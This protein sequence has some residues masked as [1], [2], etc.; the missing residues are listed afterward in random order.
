MLTAS[1][2]LAVLSL[3]FFVY[4]LW[5]LCL[6]MGAPNELAALVA[7]VGFSS[8]F[9]ARLALRGNR[10]A[11]AKLLRQG[12][13]TLLGISPVLLAVVL[14]GELILL[15]V[16]GGS[17]WVALAGLAVTGLA[18]VW[19][20]LNARTPRVVKVQLP[21]Q[22]LSQPVRFAQIS[23][24]HIGSRSSAFLGRVMEQINATAPDF[25]CITGDF[26]DQPG[27]S[28]AQLSALQSFAGPIFF[29]TGNHEYYE[30][31]DAILERLRNLGVN[32]LRQAG[33]QFGPV[34]IIGVDDHENPDRLAE[35]L[36]PLLPPRG[37]VNEP[38][39]KSFTL[40]MYH[41]PTG[42]EHAAAH[43]VD[44]MISGHT[45]DGQIYP[46]NL[47]VKR[48]FEHIRGLYKSSDGGTHLYVNQGTGT[49]GPTMRLGT[50]GEVTLFELQPA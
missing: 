25:L 32:V 18:G 47:L 8:Q 41:R 39:E 45:H 10:S 12:A 48:Q 11:L 37:P 49:W 40:L 44:L 6:W 36:P 21:A 29:S 38:H 4:P 28:E 15:F 20:F 19:G 24:V 46:F 27:I 30:D 5:R 7:T 34:Q 16:P 3:I 43:G 50:F 14:V 2:V 9:V 42:L 22:G 31:F 17:T 13:D 23:D 35:A 26:I 33:S 1:V